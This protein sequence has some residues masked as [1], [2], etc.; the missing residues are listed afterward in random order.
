MLRETEIAQAAKAYAQKYIKKGSTQLANNALAEMQQLALGAGVSD[1]R[2]KIKQINCTDFQDKYETTIEI[3]QKYSLGNC[4][5]MAEMAFYYVITEY[6]GVAA[7]ICKIE[8]G[9]HA[10]LI[11]GVG[12][13]SVICDPWADKV[14]PFFE[15]PKKLR[16]YRSDV[17]FFSAETREIQ[18]KGIAALQAAGCFTTSEYSGFYRSRYICFNY[19]KHVSGDQFIA[20]LE[21][22]DSTFCYKQGTT[23]R[24]AKIKAVLELL[25][26]FKSDFP[27]QF[28]ALG[29]LLIQRPLL[30]DD[31]LQLDLPKDEFKAREVIIKRN[32][33]ILCVFKKY[34]Y[35]FQWAKGAKHLHEKFRS[36]FSENDNREVIKRFIQFEKFIS[37]TEQLEKINDALECLNQL[38]EKRNAKDAV[39]NHKLNAASLAIEIQNTPIRDVEKDLYEKFIKGYLPILNFLK[40]LNKYDSPSNALKPNLQLEITLVTEL[41]EIIIDYS[42]FPTMVNRRALHRTLQD[43]YHDRTGF[44]V[45][46]D[47]LP[48]LLQLIKQLD[49]FEKIDSQVLSKKITAT[50]DFFKLQNTNF[51][52]EHNSNLFTTNL[53]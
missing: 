45:P 2:A 43:L 14:Y 34:L 44:K 53:I 6:P 42:L 48:A 37:L 33:S 8:N 15:W 20:P 22:Y 27:K 7:Q 25:T 32:I 4:L 31:C 29:R 41:K 50:C 47:L 5:E 3:I 23:Y 36:L 35:Y 9:D 19:L 21:Y 10:F 16:D 28:S 40:N 1:M 18:Q 12:G 11:V 39:R 26:S 52:K 24:R 51:V 13:N 38:L 17:V 49:S 46:N 30:Q